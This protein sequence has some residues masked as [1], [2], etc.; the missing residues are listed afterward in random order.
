MVGQNEDAVMG[1]LL[2][3]IISL[4]SQYPDTDEAG[5][6]FCILD[7]AATGTTQSGQLARLPE[8][9]NDPVCL[10]QRRQLKGLVNQIYAEVDRRRNSNVAEHPPIFLMIYGVQKLRELWKSEDDY[11]FAKPGEAVTDPGKQFASILRDGP[12]QGVYTIAWI[13]S[14]NNLN[15]AWERQT[16]REFEMRIVFQMSANDSST[17]IDT[18]AAG[19]L[20]Q[21]RAL[22]HSEETAMQE[23]FRPYRW[24]ADEWLDFVRERLSGPSRRTTSL[25]AGAAPT[26]SESEDSS[27]DTDDDGGNGGAGGGKSPEDFDLDGKGDSAGAGFSDS[28]WGFTTK[29]GDYGDDDEEKKDDGDGKQE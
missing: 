9:I 27:R 23:K 14:V 13:D 20:G 4:S 28:G 19:K 24:P 29:W 25:L 3:A 2:S 8:L 26:A 7:G 18:P 12:P 5:P 1:V 15:R 22:F 16:L 6:M 10:G 21:F 17:I 11:G